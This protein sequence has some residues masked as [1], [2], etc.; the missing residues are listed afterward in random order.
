MRI[1]EVDDMHK[2]HI[3]SYFRLLMTFRVSGT[4]FVHLRYE[5]G[6]IRKGRNR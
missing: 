4:P 2:L 5:K 6:I 3:A 1:Q